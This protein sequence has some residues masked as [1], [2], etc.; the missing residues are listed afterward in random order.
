MIT[1]KGNE[2]E[3]LK[4]DIAQFVRIWYHKHVVLTRYEIIL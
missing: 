1:W 2:A 4:R 3:I